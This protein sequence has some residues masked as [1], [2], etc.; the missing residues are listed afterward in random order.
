MQLH[1]KLKL[2]RAASIRQHMTYAEVCWHMLAY[3]ATLQ[4]QAC[5]QR[6][7]FLQMHTSAYVSELLFYSRCSNKVL[8]TRLTLTRLTLLTRLSLLLMRL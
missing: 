3:A 1:S 4:T 8:L 6:A 5:E 7:A 2:L